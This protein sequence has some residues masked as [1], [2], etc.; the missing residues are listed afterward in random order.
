MG[1]FSLSGIQR[2][3]ERRAALEERTVVGRYLPELIFAPKEIKTK[4]FVLDG[5]IVIPVQGRLH[6]VVQA[7]RAKRKWNGSAM[8]IYLR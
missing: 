6:T 1:W 7:A 8:S 4:K 5:E 3:E 2:R